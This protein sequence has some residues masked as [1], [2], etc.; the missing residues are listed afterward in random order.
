LEEIRERFRPLGLNTVHIANDAGEF[1]AFG[2]LL[3]A[4]FNHRAN[5]LNNTV[6]GLLMDKAAAQAEFNRLKAKLKLK[7]PLPMNKQKNDKKNFAF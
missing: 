2:H 7:C 4:Y 5:L 1:T 6:Q 3:F